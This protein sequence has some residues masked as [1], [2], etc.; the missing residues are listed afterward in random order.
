M[1]SRILEHYHCHNRFCFH[2]FTLQFVC[3]EHTH[4]V[5]L[6]GISFF[7]ECFIVVDS[8]C[9]IY[10]RWSYKPAIQARDRTFNLVNQSAIQLRIGHHHHH[11]HHHCFCSRNFSSIQSKAVEKKAYN[12]VLKVSYHFFSSLR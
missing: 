4:G 11:R 5:N 12:N 8:Q 10:P 6:S 9:C 1:H 7:I 2:F 3:S